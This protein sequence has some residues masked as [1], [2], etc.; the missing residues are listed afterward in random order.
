MAC[1]LAGL[2]AKGS[3]RSNVEIAFTHCNGLPSVLVTEGGERS[4]LVLTEVVDDK[5][6]ALYLVRNPE[7][8]ARVG[9]TPP[10]SGPQ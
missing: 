6:S 3:G 9:A 7:K 4:L 10:L 8:L 1:F 5:V 2:F